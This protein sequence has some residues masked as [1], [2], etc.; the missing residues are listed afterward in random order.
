MTKKTNKFFRTGVV[1]VLLKKVDGLLRSDI[2]T[3]QNKARKLVTRTH[4]GRADAESD[5]SHAQLTR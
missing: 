2:E 4:I 1:Y 5:G 3:I